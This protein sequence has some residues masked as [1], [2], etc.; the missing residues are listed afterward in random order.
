MADGQARVM[1]RASTAEIDNHYQKASTVCCHID[2]LVGTLSKLHDDSSKWRAKYINMKKVHFA[3]FL[4]TSDSMRAHGTFREW[5]NCWLETKAGKEHAVLLVEEEKMRKEWTKKKEQQAMEHHHEV[6]RVE[7]D[8][9]HAIFEL[10]RKLR[11]RQTEL[12]RLCDDRDSYKQSAA[13]ATRVLRSMR[14]QMDSLDEDPSMELPDVEKSE[15][16]YLSSQL[17]KLLEAVDP[18]FVPPMASAPCPHNF[19]TLSSGLY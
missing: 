17:Y 10:A 14:G 4:A 5:K 2:D 11:E 8:Q 3:K 19:P 7:A 1:R 12:E 6:K 13:R 15:F 9:K 16:E 18:K